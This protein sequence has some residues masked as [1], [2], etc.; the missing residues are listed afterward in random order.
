MQLKFLLAFLI[1][2]LT[3]PALAQ[4]SLVTIDVSKSFYAE[5][6]TVVI[7]GRVAAVIEDMP[8]TIQIIYND[9]NIIGV[10]Q[11]KPAE[12]GSFT[13]TVIAQGPL[14]QRDGE[15]IVRASYG[16]NNVSDAKFSFT[17]MQDNPS[18]ENIF[19]V[20]VEG[21]GTFDVKYTI[22]GGTMQD[23]LIDNNIYALVSIIN[24]TSDGSLTL[25]LPR[26]SIDA[27]TNGCN[28]GDEV[29]IVLIDGVEVPYQELEKNTTYRVITMEFES[30]DKDIEVIG[31]CVIPEFGG[32]AAAVLA[33]AI[34]SVIVMSRRG[35][36]S[37]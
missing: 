21:G 19:E 37:I 15:Y 25:E 7:S 27:R 10:A 9:G 30:D 1:I 31:T 11:I 32:V 3:A 16:T 18:I 34:I 17:T 13:H 5:G 26:G 33:V 22:N 20:G 2:P 36:P 23:M 28:G 29:Y 14:W 4:E 8:V 24:A 6:D 12:D 35:M